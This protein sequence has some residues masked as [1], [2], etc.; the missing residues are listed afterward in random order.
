MQ[1]S[2]SPNTILLEEAR[3]GRVQGLETVLNDVSYTV[4]VNGALDQ[5][6]MSPLCLACAGGHEDAAIFL[7]ERAAA[8]PNNDAGSTA[9]AAAVAAAGA[10]TARSDQGYGGGDS[11]DSCNKAR[12]GARYGAPPTPLALAVNAGLWRAV[13]EL[14]ARGARVDTS[15]PED[16]W[17]VLHLCASVG[18]ALIM[19]ALLAAPLADPGVRTHRL[20][21]PLSIASACGHLAIVDMLLGGDAETR[22]GRDGDSG[23]HDRHS[24]SLPIIE[25]DG[26]VGGDKASRPLY[27]HAEERTWAGRTP[28]HRAAAQGHTE[29]TL[30]LLAHGV[31]ADP[32]DARG[33]TPLILAARQGH[34]GAVKALA[35]TGTASVHAATREG[36][37]ALHA[38]A[39][40][41]HGGALDV[42]K[43]LL[44]SGAK[45]N[46]RNHFGSTGDMNKQYVRLS[47]L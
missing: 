10:T 9:V 33:A 19:H 15:R 13:N 16:G 11:Y 29:V 40:A 6:F 38:A 5:I 47:A 36:D 42:L 4:D 17:T 14:L 18:D 25:T 23:T 26:L 43:F 3:A 8:D 22:S 34:A 41:G 44:N 35:R 32:A 39:W 31:S 21:T 28:L 45:V 24:T 20:E 46:A 30:R 7:L 2:D 1:T 12:I 37:T 27:R